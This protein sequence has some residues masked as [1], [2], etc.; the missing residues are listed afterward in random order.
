MR[1]DYRGLGDGEADSAASRTSRRICVPPSVHFANMPAG[2]RGGA[3]GGL[4]RCSGHHDQCL[5]AAGG[6]RNR[7]RQPMGA[8]AG[9]AMPS[10]SSTTSASA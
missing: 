8:H 9:R 7:H 2:A 3:V 4:R 6:D 10:S 5:E 1:F